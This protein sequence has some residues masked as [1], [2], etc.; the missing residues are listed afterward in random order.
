MTYFSKQYLKK[1]FLNKVII[2]NQLDKL[3]KNNKTLMLKI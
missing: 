3:D 2:K 1:S